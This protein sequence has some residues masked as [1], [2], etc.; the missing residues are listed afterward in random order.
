MKNAHERLGLLEFHKQLRDTKTR[1]RVALD[2]FIGEPSESK[3]ATGVCHLV[4]I[5]GNDVDIGA[6]W[7]AIVGQEWLTVSGPD[8]TQRTVSLGKDPRVLRGTVAVAGR[9]R[10]VRHLM[11]LSS[12]MADET[13]VGRIILSQ[14]NPEFVLYRISQRLGLPVHPTWANWF[15]SALVQQKRTQPLDGLGYRPLAVNGTKDEFLQWIGTAVKRKTIEIPKEDN[16]VDWKSLNTG[17][18]G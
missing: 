11:A 5:F 10:S 6:I 15:W 14:G 7:A 13:D 18:L 3:E 16:S 9:T 1:I 4:S 8:L 2:R 17:N 12:Q